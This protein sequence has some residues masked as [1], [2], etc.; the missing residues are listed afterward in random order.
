[1]QVDSLTAADST[2]GESGFLSD[3]KDAVVRIATASQLKA[4]Q[5]KASVM[6]LTVQ[7]NKQA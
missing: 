4:N 1:M 6:R 7:P 3:R 5:K 2:K